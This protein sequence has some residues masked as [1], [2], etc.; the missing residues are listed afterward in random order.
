ME[1][2][3]AKERVMIQGIS[4]IDYLDKA[5]GGLANNYL[6]VTFG[7]QDQ[8]VL[9]YRFSLWEDKPTHKMFTSIMQLVNSGRLS[10]AEH[11]VQSAD[12]PAMHGSPA[13]FTP[14]S[15]QIQ[16]TTFGV[17]AA[18]LVLD[19]Q[20][21]GLV[22]GSQQMMGQVQQLH[23]T[24][25]YDMTSRILGIHVQV[26]MGGMPVEDA[27][28]IQLGVESNGTITGFDT[29]GNQYAFRRNVG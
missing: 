14:G 6:S 1:F 25:G 17:A 19:F 15:W 20:P 27:R 26:N 3:S 29:A 18:Q 13:G 11:F 4:A 16:I 21:Q 10:A 2:I 23:G 9:F 5:Q 28:Q 12:A 7:D 24:W 8:V 22:S